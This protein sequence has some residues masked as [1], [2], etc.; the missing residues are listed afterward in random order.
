MRPRALRIGQ[1][2]FSSIQVRQKLPA[3]AGGTKASGESIGVLN[4]LNEWGVAE[5]HYGSDDLQSG[6]GP[7]ADGCESGLSA[8]GLNAPPTREINAAG[9]WPMECFR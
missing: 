7:P 3:H 2:E 4:W 5:N 9:H 6:R 8:Q 1:L